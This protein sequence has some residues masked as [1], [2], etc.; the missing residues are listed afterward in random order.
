[1]KILYLDC[2]AGAAGDMLMAALVDAGASE[3]YVHAQV[4]ALGLAG[5]TLTFMEK[6][7]CGIRASQAHVDTGSPEAR[8]LE[9]LHRIL[10]TAE[11]DDR[12]RRRAQET[13]SLLA[14]AEATVHGVPL[15]DAHLHEAGND[16]ALLR[17][18]TCARI[19]MRNRL[20]PRPQE[21]YV[22]SLE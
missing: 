16:D 20:S 9:E 14:G 4:N 22:P 8:R 6:T 13:F 3:S 7:T 11:L 17:W 15:T 10:D 5:T 2:S 19:I 12:V 21:E 1:M 18:N